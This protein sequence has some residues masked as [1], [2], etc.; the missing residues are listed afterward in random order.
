MSAATPLAGRRIG[1]LTAW[2][3]RAN[4][5]VFEAVAQQARMIEALGG[6][7]HVIALDDDPPA[8]DRARFGPGRV[9]LSP[10][11][12]PAQVGYAPDLVAAIERVDP[13]LLHLHGIWMYPSRAGAVWAR[14]S[15]KPYVVSPHGMLDPWITARG[16]AKKALARLGYERASWRSARFLHALTTREAADIARE[17]RRADSVVI[18]NAGPPA[19]AAPAGERAASFV[20]LGRIHPKKN[21]GALIAGWKLAEPALAAAGAALTIAGWGDP[22]DVAQLRGELAGAPPSVAFVGAVYGEAKAR[23]LRQARFLVL[24]SHSEGLP[25]VVLEAWAAATPVLMTQECNLPEGFA[26]GAAIDCGYDPATIASALRRAVA[27]PAGEWL[28]LAE[29]GRA[30]AQGRFSADSVAREWAAAY[31]GA[32]EPS[33]LA[34]SVA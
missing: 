6:E 28:A 9:H 25:M 7:A 13:D 18:P 20:Y 8:E 34:R 27:M 26:A 11:N 2:A 23:L 3:S 31:T 32:I 22:D 12:G 33:A 15:G 17:T 14:R 16:R 4:G 21:I 1:L 5:G 24:P 19:E 10:V 30:L 29:A